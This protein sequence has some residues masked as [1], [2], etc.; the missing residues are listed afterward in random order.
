MALACSIFDACLMKTA[1]QFIALL[2]VCIGS[3]GIVAAE[4]IMRQGVNMGAGDVL[5]C[6]AIIRAHL[7]NK[8]GRAA[9]AALSG[10]R[11]VAMTPRA[12]GFNETLEAKIREDRCDN[13]WGLL[14]EMRGLAE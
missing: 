8:D 10:M 3:R 6:L 14:D 12:M 1:G 2:D 9:W 11:A 5:D 4:K 7:Q 13:A